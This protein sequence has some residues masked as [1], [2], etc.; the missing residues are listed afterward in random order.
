M[1]PRF[2]LWCWGC[3]RFARGFDFFRGPGPPPHP[4]S[5]GGGSDGGGLCDSHPCPFPLPFVTPL[6]VRFPSLDPAGVG[7]GLDVWEGVVGMASDAGGCAVGCAVG[8]DEAEKIA[9]SGSVVGWISGDCLSSG[10]SWGSRRKRFGRSLRSSRGSGSS[11][12]RSVFRMSAKRCASVRCW[13]Q[14]VAFVSR[15]RKKRVKAPS[16]STLSV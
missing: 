9:D 13:R 3:R 2:F 1:Y 8:G 7:V 15:S 5:C 11:S 16:S 6:L 4:S 14:S 10:T 12:T